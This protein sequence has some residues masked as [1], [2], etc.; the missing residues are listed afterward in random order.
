[1][2]RRRSSEPPAILRRLSRPSVKMRG[3]GS[4]IGRGVPLR[5]ALATQP[6]LF[7]EI[8]TRGLSEGP[9][10][11]I[12]GRAGAPD[13][14]HDI[15]SLEKPE[16]LVLDGEALDP[17]P[18]RVIRRVRMAAPST[19][20]LV[21]ASRSDNGTV[22]RALHAGASGVVGKDQTLATLVRA[23]VAVASGNLWAPRRIV[24]RITDRSVSAEA[25][26]PR[27]ARSRPN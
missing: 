1:M 7:L 13:E 4:K 18:E 23:V 26:G 3:N 5:V 25:P 8:L 11:R 2:S 24:A 12:V 15:L 17:S 22:A 21:L 14:L 20:I 10:L 6:P 27:Q 19:R 9:S 16:V